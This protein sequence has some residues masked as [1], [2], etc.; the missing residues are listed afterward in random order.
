MTNS[1]TKNALHVLRL[2]P[3]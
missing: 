1:T 3:V 2:A